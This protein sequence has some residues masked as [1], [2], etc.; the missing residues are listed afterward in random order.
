MVYR[1]PFK[2]KYI[3]RAFLF[4]RKGSKVI[5]IKNYKDITIFKILNEDKFLEMLFK[6]QSD[7]K[8]IDELYLAK[9]INI[10]R[11]SNFISFQR[12]LNMYG[13]KKINSSEYNGYYVNAF[14]KFNINSSDEEILTIE[15]NDKKCDYECPFKV[16]ACSKLDKERSKRKISFEVK[17]VRKS[18]RIRSN[19]KDESLAKEK[20]VEYQNE[21]KCDLNDF[22][23]DNFIDYEYKMSKLG[24]SNLIEDLK[25]DYDYSKVLKQE[26]L[27]SELNKYLD[28]KFSDIK[29]SHIYPDND[30]L[31]TFRLV[32]D[33]KKFTDED[34]H[35][36]T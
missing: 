8:K 5:N 34:L 30:D 6:F 16:R 4:N 28:W 19:F 9:I 14:H 21:H 23:D 20:V 12:Q 35:I 3:L 26:N 27:D 32:D 31:W 7:L 17:S 2:L 15:R 10:A 33:S 24:E 25:D 18:K 22:Q 13:F 29:F 1:F 11:N 36:F